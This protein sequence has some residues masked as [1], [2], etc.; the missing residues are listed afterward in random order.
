MSQTELAR[1]VGVKQPSIARLEGRGKTT[2]LNFLGRVAKALDARLEVRLVP[3]KA[4]GKPGRQKR[5]T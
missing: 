4:G 3:R 5:M 2:N 1:R